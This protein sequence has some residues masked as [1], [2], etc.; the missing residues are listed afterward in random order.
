M[1]GNEWVVEDAAGD[2]YIYIRAHTFWSDYSMECYVHIPE[3]MNVE[4]LAAATVTVAAYG[5]VEWSR[6]LFKSRKWISIFYPS[7]AT[8]LLYI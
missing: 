7:P 8:F 1:N 3:K 4:M 6:R 2:T 5:V